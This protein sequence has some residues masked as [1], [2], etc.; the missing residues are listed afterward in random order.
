MNIEASRATHALQVQT[1]KP[2]LPP[3]LAPRH[4]QPALLGSG[5]LHSGQYQ[6]ALVSM[7]NGDLESQ[8]LLQDTQLARL[9]LLPLTWNDLLSH[10]SSQT[11]ET[12]PEAPHPISQFGDVSIDLPR[13]EVRRARQTI[14]LTSLEFKVLKFFLVNPHRVISREEFLKSVWGYR[15]YPVT[16]S[17]DNQILRLRQ[18]LERNPAD[19]IHFQTVHGAGYKFVP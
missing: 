15:W 6:V 8:R 13:H 2:G 18:K 9:L 14:E 7:S 12:Q 16:R 4:A 10:L 17:V 11:L 5:E 1:L 3:T 19:P